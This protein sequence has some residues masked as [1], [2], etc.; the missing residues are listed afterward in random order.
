MPESGTE[1]AELKLAAKTCTV[2]HSAPVSKQF[3]G[4]SI[5]FSW[6][7]LYPSITIWTPSL[8][9]QHSKDKLL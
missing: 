5:F 9:G 1:K 8:K 7:P 2:Y 6:R 4:Y 3:A